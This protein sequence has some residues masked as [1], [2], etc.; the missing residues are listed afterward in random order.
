MK[1]TS[2]SKYC[3]GLALGLALPAMTAAAS[4][5]G[6]LYTMDNA[7]GANHVLVFQRSEHGTL[8]NALSVATGGAGA[9][10][11]LSSQGS[12][13]LSRDS[14]WLFA[15]NPG[16]SEISVFAVSPEGLSLS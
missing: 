2:F 9:G 15:C 11:G 12:V 8:G 14:R 6:L 4:D 13:L 10:A 16:S 5:G 7:A 1:R 3:S